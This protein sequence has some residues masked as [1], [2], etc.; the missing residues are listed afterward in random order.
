M[1]HRS[2]VFKRYKSRLVPRRKRIP[3]I[4]LSFPISIDRGRKKMEQ[5]EPVT[6]VLFDMDGLLLD[7]EEIYSRA[8]QEV[9]DRHGGK[10]FTWELKVR[11]MGLV[12]AD[13]A[14]LVVK[15]L[16]LPITT[17]E[18]LAEVGPVNV[19]LF[20]SANLMPGAERLLRH[21]HSKGVHIAVAT[22]SSR[23]NFELKTTHHGGVFQ[24]FKHI[25]TGSSDPE[26]K[27]GKPAPDIFLICASRFPEPAP[28]PSKCLVFEDAPN[29]VKAAR[30][31]GMQVV[32]VPDPRMDPLLTQEATLVLKSLEEFKPELFGLPAFD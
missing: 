22:S 24:L 8:I 19:R 31:A 25:V 32:M 9:S 20:P 23:E 13:L 29:G 27:A 14:A 7:S 6:H 17:E 15:E 16:Q 2:L 1:C 11:Q 4:N 26:V 3:T 21:L 12:S 5:F 30:A 10:A 28:H 18:Y